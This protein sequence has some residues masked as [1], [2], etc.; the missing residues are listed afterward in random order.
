[1][2]NPPPI[3]PADQPAEPERPRFGEYAPAAEPHAAPPAAP[4]YA[5]PQPQQQYSQPQPPQNPYAQQQYPQQ[6]LPPQHQ[7]PQQPLYSQQNPYGTPLGAPK[8]KGVGVVAFVVGLVV[9][10]AT[11]IVVALATAAFAPGMEKAYNGAGGIDPELLN[12]SETAQLGGAAFGLF[13]FLAVATILGLWA[14]IQGIIATARNRGRVFGILAMVFAIV[15][16]IVG[17]ITFY[18]VLLS[19]APGLIDKMQQGV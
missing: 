16:P 18:S 7:A 3:E 19:S 9:L 4:Q 15:A 6:Q 14:L 10:I 17:I 13:A 1:V 8:P 12:E 5:Q 11:P 2:T